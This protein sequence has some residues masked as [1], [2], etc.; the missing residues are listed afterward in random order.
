MEPDQMSDRP[1]AVLLNIYLKY[2]LF[3]FRDDSQYIYIIYTLPELVV[4]K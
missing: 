3:I 1:G 4:K 2:N